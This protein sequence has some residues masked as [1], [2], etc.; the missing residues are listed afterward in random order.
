MREAVS[1]FSNWLR[2]HMVG[3][4]RVLPKV[5]GRGRLAKMAN[6]TLIVCGAS[7]VAIAKMTAGHSLI[8]DCRLFSHCMIL[9][10]GVIGIEDALKTLIAFL[11]PGGV[12][13]DVGA[14]I[15]T[16]TVP[17]ALA[18]KRVGSHVIAFEPFPRNVEWIGKNLNLNHLEDQ[19]TVVE[20]GLSSEP[21][22]AALL[23][24][25]DF[26]TGAEIGNAS[27]AEP[28]ISNHYRRVTVKLN[29]LDMLWPG[30]G[31]PRLD[32]IK[33]DIEGHEDRF[34][35]GAKQTL[36]ANR[37]VI[38]ME[39]NRRFYTKRGLDF[40]V[41]IPQLLPPDY[42]FFTA[43]QIEIKSLADCHESDVLLVPEE[44][45]NQLRA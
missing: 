24:R 25:E 2:P 9:F 19:V 43:G 45:A 31:S 36:A 12:A 27:I 16:V 26:E 29:T 30:F 7:P 41:L 4:I 21:G 35:V 22:E 23:L 6:D 34:L 33:I 32:I 14:N 15:G 38:I 17:L 18:A 11:K 20:S 37:P 8:L 28:G 40:N 13:L 10:L 44:K 5:R 1:G 39:V 3:V 42:R